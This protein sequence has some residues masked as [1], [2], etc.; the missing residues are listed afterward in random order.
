MS[1]IIFA[2]LLSSLSL[3]TTKILA[4]HATELRDASSAYRDAASHFGREVIGHRHLGAYEKRVGYDLLRLSSRMQLY[5]R[6]PSLGSRLRDC[7]WDLEDLHRRIEVVIF[8]QPDCPVAMD[9][10]PCYR[11]L[12][13]A[14]YDLETALSNVG[15]Y[16]RHGE[17]HLHHSRVIPLN[18]PNRYER[19]TLMESVLGAVMS[20]LESSQRR[21]VYGHRDHVFG[22]EHVT[23]QRARH[24]NDWSRSLH[25]D[26]GSAART[27]SRDFDSRSPQVNHVDESRGRKEIDKHS[28]HRKE[29][30][31][32]RHPSVNQASNHDQGAS[33][34][35]EH[36]RHSPSRSGIQSRQA[37]KRPLASASAQMNASRLNEKNAQRIIQASPQSKAMNHPTVQS[38]SRPTI[39]SKDSPSAK[40]IS[41]S[42]PGRS[43]KSGK[44]SND[45]GEPKSYFR[46][47]KSPHDFL[48]K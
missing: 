25:H 40:S 37:I 35:N 20:G 13:C 36:D 45:S 8:A 3:T 34:M 41:S 38:T 19:P 14:F 18:G 31:D 21:S 17:I 48:K 46:G 24:G 9:L 33:R 27:N 11:E 6:T 43:P 15:C 29:M 44:S 5:C 10:T 32:T 1:K 47:G 23:G 39:S 28:D 4:S 7:W 26:F 16:H 30:P 12:M 42:T 2:I 22:H